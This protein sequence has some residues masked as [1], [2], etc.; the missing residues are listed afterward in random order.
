MAQRALGH[1]ESA[2]ERQCESAPGVGSRR[3]KNQIELPGHD[4]GSNHCEQDSKKPNLFT[5]C[6]L[7]PFVGLA[8]T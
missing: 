7:G 4:E 5:E 2:R 3:R 1:H 8:F 6:H